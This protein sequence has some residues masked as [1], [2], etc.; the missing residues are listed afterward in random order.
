MSV[1][2]RKDFVL[3]AVDPLLPRQLASYLE[4]PVISLYEIPDLDPKDIHQLL[5]VDPNAWSAI[6]VS[7]E[8]GELI[9]TNTQHQG[10]RPSTDIMHELSHLLL[11]HEPATMFFIGV[12]DFALRGFNKDSE[13]EADWLGSSL[14]L[15]RSV[16]VHIQ[17]THIP[18][19]TVFETYEVSQRLLEYRN[20]MTGVKRQFTKRSGSRG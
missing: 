5:E 15:P 14:L 13:E 20:R 10:G 19:S 18:D 6:T 8:S 7:N 17:R 12:E 1:G 9:I 11:G 2:L 16:L 4:V 3:T